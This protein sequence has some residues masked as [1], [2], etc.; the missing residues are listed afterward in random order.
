M[1][2]RYH[3]PLTFQT[4]VVGV[5]VVFA[6]VVVVVAVALQEKENKIHEVVELCP[7]F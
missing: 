5:V 4:L 3:F 7:V 6:V 2:N 1:R